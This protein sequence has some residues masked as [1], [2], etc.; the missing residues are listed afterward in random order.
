M[1]PTVLLVDDDDALELFIGRAL[2][3]AGVRLSLKYVSS[4]DEC[5][6]YLLREGNYKDTTQYPNPAV[7]ILDLKMPGVSGF[8]VLEW[9]QQQPH[10][11]FIPV[12]VLSSSDLER[13]R[14]FALALGAVAYCVK[15]LNFD[16]FIPFV[17]SLEQYCSTT[18]KTAAAG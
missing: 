2:Q 16:D 11:N 1:F 3:K 13:D 7:M 8:R 6:R 4:G 14:Q 15:P 5:V 9:K 12:V 17:K 10:L 18:A